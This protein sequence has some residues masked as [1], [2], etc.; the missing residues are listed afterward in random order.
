MSTNDIS[1]AKDPDLRASLDALRRAAQLARK[2]AIQTDTNLVIVKDGQ[3]QRI[4][5][6]ELRQQA[7]TVET[8]KGE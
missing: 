7:A 8:P 6:D 4:S 3:I 5:A 2:T 1:D